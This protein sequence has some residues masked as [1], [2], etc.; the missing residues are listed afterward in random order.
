LR[1]AGLDDRDGYCRHD[2][3]NPLSPEK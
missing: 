3:P 2:F 1:T